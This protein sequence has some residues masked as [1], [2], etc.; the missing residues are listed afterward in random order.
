MFTGL[1]AQLLSWWHETSLPDLRGVSACFQTWHHHQDGNWLASS[2]Q[3]SPLR[4]SSREDLTTLN[5][6]TW[7]VDSGAPSSGPRMRALLDAIESQTNADVIFL[8][9]VN[10]TALAQLI[11]HPW[12]ERNWYC[13]DVDDTN[14]GKQAFITVTL[15]SRRLSAHLGHIW[16]V[17]L[18]SRFGRDALCCDIFVR[19]N[20][21]QT[22][23]RLVNV[24][25]DS[26]PITPSLRPGQLSIVAK[27]LETAGRGIVA[28]DF[29]PVL[30][31]DEGILAD[32]GL[33]DSWTYL[34]PQEAGFTWGFRNDKPF[35]PRRMD[36]VAMLNVEPES[37]RIL[38]MASVMYEDKAID[39]S[40][41]LGLA[42][43]FRCK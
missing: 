14:F 34:Y 2:P 40:D 18:P 31:E 33:V 22:P 26:L 7:N 19:N 41:H 11:D 25:L 30:P 38:Q 21:Q 42:C 28:G 13:S 20:R 43:T 15:F 8:Q 9:E 10:K 12:I 35:P 3:I 23:V 17:A 5:I 32:N 1:R 39:F 36:K 37:M 16:R 4:E 27:Y 24:H 29:N 6:V